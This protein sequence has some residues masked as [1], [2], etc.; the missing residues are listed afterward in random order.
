MVLKLPKLVR[1]LQIYADLSKKFKSIKAIYLY[2]SERPHQTLS[3][4]SI[5]YRVLTNSSQD[6]EE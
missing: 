6:I 3:E 1:F 2:P 4:N 5:F